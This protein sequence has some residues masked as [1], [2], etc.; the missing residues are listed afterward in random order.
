[1]I[2]YSM[3]SFEITDFIGRPD[4]LFSRQQLGLFQALLQALLPQLPRLQ[5]QREEPRELPNLSL[6][7]A[8]QAISRHEASFRP[9]PSALSGL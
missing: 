4:Q 8:S 2:S 7:S 1:M 3:L 5:F 6:L 9:C